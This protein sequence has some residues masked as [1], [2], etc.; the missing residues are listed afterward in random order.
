MIFS[1]GQVA[2]MVARIRRIQDRE[3]YLLRKYL[4]R[5]LAGEHQT[6]P[7]PASATISTS[8]RAGG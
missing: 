6:A 7:N 1:L 2:A 8:D 5:A 3:L 4:D